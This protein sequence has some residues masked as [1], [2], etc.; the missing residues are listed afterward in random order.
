SPDRRGIDVGLVYRKEGIVLLKSKAIPVRDSLDITFVTRDILYAK[1]EIFGADTL[2]VFINHW[3]SRY[4]GVLASVDKRMLVARLLR[5]HVDSLSNVSEMPKI[6]IMGDF[7]DDPNDLS[8]VDG[9]GAFAIDKI[10]SPNQL[11]NLFAIPDQL[12][13]Q[14]TIKYMQNWQIFDQIIISQ[15]LMHANQRLRLRKNSARIFLRDFLLTDD[16]RH[17]GKM[18]H[19]TFSG[20]RYIGGYSDHLPIYVDLECIR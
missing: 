7:N 14:G 9:L 16:E 5:H 10:N 20:P 11:V 3:P 15:S 17:L 12:G 2:H 6:L 4:G 13:S 1:F 18:L 8:L 19:R